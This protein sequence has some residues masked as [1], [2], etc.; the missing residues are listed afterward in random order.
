MRPFLLLL[1]LLPSYLSQMKPDLS[2]DL[3][4]CQKGL[5]L[6]FFYFFDPQLIH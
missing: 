1:L 4:V 2:F 5:A 3:Y 6:N